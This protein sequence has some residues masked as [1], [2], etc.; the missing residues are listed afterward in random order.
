MADDGL[1]ERWE[2]THGGEKKVRQGLA[3]SLSRC[4]QA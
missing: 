1:E 2:K 3:L 4:E